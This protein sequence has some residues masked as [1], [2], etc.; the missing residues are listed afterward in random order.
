MK[1]NHLATFEELARK[2]NSELETIFSSGKGPEPEALA[3]YEWRG[4]NVPWWASIL[5]IRKFIKGFF[6]RQARVE[7]YNIP[8]RQNALQEPWIPKPNPDNPKRFGFFAVSKVDPASQENLYPQATL[9]NYG[10]SRL[11]P[12][13]DPT[14]LLRDYVVQPDPQN[15]DLLLGKAYLALG[16]SRVFTNFFLI[17]RLRRTSWF[18]P[19][20]ERP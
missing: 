12:R 10:A 19:A 20:T 17:Q 3:G 15:P 1:G 6:E 7:G 8:V 9:L 13:L 14:R 4:Y 11:N 18:P 16:P 2:S 5:G